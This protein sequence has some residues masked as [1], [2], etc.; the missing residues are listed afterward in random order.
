[1][2]V[3]IQFGRVLRDLRSGRG[4]TQ[5]ELAYRA[6]MSVPYLSELERGKNNPSLSML[7]DLAKA[8]EIHPTDLLRPLEIGEQGDSAPRKRP[9]E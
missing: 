7:V 8:L 1:M 3:R 2:D 4:L 6:G 5:E 9:K